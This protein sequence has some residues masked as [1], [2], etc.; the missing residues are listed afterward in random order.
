MVD[1]RPKRA[2][3]RERETLSLMLFLNNLRSML[4]RNRNNRNERAFIRIQKERID[5]DDDDDQRR[6]E[7]RIE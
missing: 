2:S 7:R 5:D 6:E 4:P 3:E 1:S